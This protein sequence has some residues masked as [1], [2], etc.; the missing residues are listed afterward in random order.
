MRQTS[1]RF[2]GVL[3]ADIDNTLFNWVDSFAPAFRA[4]VHALSRELDVE[5]NDL[6]KEFRDVYSSRGSLEYSFAI[7]E[8]EMVKE[9]PRDR[10]A[11]LIRIGRGA[12][13]HVRRHRLSAYP[14]VESTLS[15]ISNQGMATVA[16]TNASAFN[17]QRRLYELGLDKHCYGIAAWEGYEKEAA[18]AVNSTYV[19][20]GRVRRK[21]RFNAANIWLLKDAS[22]KPNPKVYQRI[23]EE[24]KL[25]ASQAWAIGD[26]P[27]GDLEPAASLGIT[28]VWARYGQVVDSRNLDTILRIVPW[29][30]EEI[31]Q[32]QA[33]GSSPNYTIDR[34]EELQDILPVSQA[35]LF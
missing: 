14:G 31:A 17:A 16:V 22:K 23:L 20:S 19:P 30:D 34:F 15:W 9:F 3:L 32:H 35:T 12:F 1:G 4:M 28:T 5:E 21:T 6:Y 10:I 11:D 24:M 27:I 29:S 25:S 8:L 33:E 18:D 26:S 7:Q 13:S 2:R